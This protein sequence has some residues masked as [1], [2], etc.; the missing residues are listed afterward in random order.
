[1]LNIQTYYA[2]V[3]EIERPY[4]M[5]AT[6]TEFERMWELEVLD[7]IPTCRLQEP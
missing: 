5:E 7:Q 4:N 2:R 6:E 1:M 3:K